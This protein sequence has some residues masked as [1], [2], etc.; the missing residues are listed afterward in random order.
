MEGDPRPRGLRPSG[1]RRLKD[2]S[3]LYLSDRSPSAGPPRPVVRRLLRLGLTGGAEAAVRA[4]VCANLA[5]QFA[6]LRQRTI[7]L[8][9]DP[10]LPNVG[11]RLGLE[12]RDY[13]AHLWPEQGPRL[14]RSVL[15]VRVLCG[16]NSTTEP[17]EELLREVRGSDCVLVQLPASSDDTASVLERLWPLLELP[18]PTTMARAASQS[19]M[20]E[21]WMASAVR[22]PRPAARLERA[23][24]ARRAGFD[25]GLAV[26]DRVPA[27]GA[28]AAMRETLGRGAALPVHTMLWGETAESASPVWARIPHHPLQGGVRQPVSSLDPEHTVSRLYESLTQALLAG[29]GT[30]GSH[31][32]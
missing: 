25:A 2:I 7:V 29:L 15:G 16:W 26:H 22:A 8:D 5:V 32:V 13:L 24:L 1:A 4:D 31:D 3:H 23:S 6:R 21:A 28:E 9:L 10:R 17:T 11:H 19:P 20:F 27:P 14:R 30:R 18:A 12:A